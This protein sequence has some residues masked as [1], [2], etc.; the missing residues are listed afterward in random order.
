MWKIWEKEKTAA[1]IEN[2]TEGAV[3]E[4][5]IAPNLTLHPHLEISFTGEQSSSSSIRI[6]TDS[7]ITALSTKC[8]DKTLHIPLCLAEK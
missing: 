5:K 4:K 8:T 6:G 3:I 7:D 2:D 1:A